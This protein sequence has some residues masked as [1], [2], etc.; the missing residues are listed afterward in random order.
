MC[1]PR[2]AR[3][4][5][6]RRNRT[7]RLRAAGGRRRAGGSAGSGAAISTS[8]GS[9]IYSTPL[10][11]TPTPAV[12]TT[13][14]PGA[15]AAALRDRLGGRRKVI[16]EVAQP[17]VKASAAHAARQSG[18][19]M[20][21]TVAIASC[22][23]G[24]AAWACTNEAMHG[25]GQYGITSH[26]TRPEGCSTAGPSIDSTR[27]REI[28]ARCGDRGAPVRSKLQTDSVPDASCAG[29]AAKEL[30]FLAVVEAGTQST[31]HAR[32]ASHAGGIAPCLR[33]EPHGERAPVARVVPPH[34][35]AF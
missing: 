21:H 18:S 26:S 31:T 20:P 3:A 33:R 14:C 1:C 7:R 17:S 12:P 30:H 10:A 22:Q 15:A 5:C 4:P 23:S 24:A 13:R 32:A 35:H 19:A 34:D 11:S 16:A 8:A 9:S 25:G 29:S 27:A 28:R 2:H 6:A